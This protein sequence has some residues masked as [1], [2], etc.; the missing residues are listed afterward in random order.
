MKT[1]NQFLNQVMSRH[2]L[3]SDYQLA[4]FLGITRSAISRYRNKPGAGFDEDI[5]LKVAAALEINPVFVMANMNAAKTKSADAREAWLS[6]AAR[7]AVVVLVIV[8]AL[9]VTEP[10]YHESFLILVD[11]ACSGPLCIMLNP[12]I[13]IV[14][15]VLLILFNLLPFTPNNK[16]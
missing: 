5:A 16:H 6:I 9:L 8:G 1:A 3:T 10:L 4:H 14:A 11:A 15:A 12:H 13:A 2:E 7:A